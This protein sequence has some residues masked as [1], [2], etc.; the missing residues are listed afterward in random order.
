MEI[1]NYLKLLVGY[2]GSNLDAVFAVL[3]IYIVFMFVSTTFNILT[4]II[5]GGRKWY[6]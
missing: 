5:T 2:T 6:R 4:L 3:S 1:I